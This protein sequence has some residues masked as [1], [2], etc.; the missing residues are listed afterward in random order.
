MKPT[1]F[2][3]CIVMLRAGWNG[4]RHQAYASDVRFYFL[5][6]CVGQRSQDTSF[7]AIEQAAR[8]VVRY[9]Q[10]GQTAGVGQLN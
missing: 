10:G 4:A 3:L 9:H 7:L 8:G 5:P 1:L 2:E 6:Q